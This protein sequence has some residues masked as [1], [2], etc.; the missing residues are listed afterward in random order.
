MQLVY[1][2]GNKEI[3]AIGTSNFKKNNYG[4]I[5][6]NYTAPSPQTL[7]NGQEFFT[8]CFTLLGGPPT[9]VTLTNVSVTNGEGN[10]LTTTTN[11][12]TISETVSFENFTLVAGS[13]SGAQGT[14]VCI[15]VNVFN[16]VGLAGLQFAIGYD[17]EKLSFVS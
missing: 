1:I 6:S 10:S 15:D 9:N 16:L 7:T 14:E 17:A 4:S 5:D 13:T 12:G 11:S 8:V 3:P 2:K